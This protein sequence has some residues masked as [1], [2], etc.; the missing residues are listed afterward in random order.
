MIHNCGTEAFW[1]QLVDGLATERVA[2]TAV[3][4]SHLLDLEQ[5]VRFRRA[6]PA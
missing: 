4:S 5:R 6:Y 1:R 2:V 3:A